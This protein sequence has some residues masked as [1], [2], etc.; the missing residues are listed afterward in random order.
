MSSAKP[1]LVVLGATGNQGGSVLSYYL[2]LSPSPYALRG[3][4]R[5]LS[6][7]KAL[8]LTS[9]GVEMVSGNFDDPASLE[10][11]FKGAS[12]IFSITDFWKAFADPAQRERAAASGQGIGVFSRE[13]EAQQNRNIIDA[14]AKVGTLERFI[15]SSL[16]DTN[17]LSGG[18]YP[19]V[20]HFEGK[21]NAEEYGQVTYP[22]LWQKTSVFYAGYY[23]E[24]FFEPGGSL[25]TPKLNEK[26][27]TLVLSL[28]EYISKISM[29]FYSPITDTGTLVDA[30]LRAAPGKKVIGVKRWL[31]F[32]DFT[33]LLARVLGT[34]VEFVDET[35][36]LAMGDPDLEKDYLD[37]IGFCMEFGFD[38][39]KV[40]T[41]VVQPSGLG[42]PVQ[43]EAVEEWCKRQVWN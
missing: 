33:E 8:S 37:M 20:Y 4:T 10:F 30:L 11:A 14:A 25:F 7:P 36:S 6:S 23:L 13:Y 5:N 18:K 16:P 35:P 24:N 12:A 34:G 27:D 29:P 9:F 21:A 2:S 31:S 22:D 38:G 28:A 17:K 42:V 19:H 43:L 1:L 3:V 39:G 32:R 15:F 41:S 40:D 26:K